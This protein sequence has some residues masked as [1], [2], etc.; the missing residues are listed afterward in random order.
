MPVTAADVRRLCTHTGLSPH[1]FLDLRRPTEVDL[2]G[3]P[4]SLALLPEGERLVALARDAEGACTFLRQEADGRETCSVHPARPRSCRAYP[5]DRPASPSQ[6]LGLH[7]AALCPTE[8]GHLAV[9]T[10]PAA[11]S[12]W[13]TVV[14]ERD[15]E[16]E[17]HAAWLAAWNRRQRLRR[18]LQKSRLS[19]LDFLRALTVAD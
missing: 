13:L 15:R 10:E 2:E 16:L 17:E 12:E 4:E 6:R 9:L 5:F 11:E 3:E 14:Q 18:R 1:E 7:P 19:A 8:T